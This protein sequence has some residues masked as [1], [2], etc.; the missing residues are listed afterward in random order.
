MKFFISPNFLKNIFFIKIFNVNPRSPVIG[1]NDVIARNEAIQ[2]KI[3][4]SSLLRKLSM[5][6][7]PASVDY[8]LIICGKLLFVERSTMFTLMLLGSLF[9]S[10]PASTALLPV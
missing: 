9:I 4:A 7:Q 2:K 1:R 8:F 10:I 3:G 6:R 5:T